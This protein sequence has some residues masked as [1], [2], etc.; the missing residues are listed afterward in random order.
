MTA[1]TPLVVL[2]DIYVTGLLAK[3]CNIAQTNSIHFL[4]MGIENYCKVDI[5]KDAVIHRVDIEKM[6]KR[7]IGEKVL[8][9]IQGLEDR[10]CLDFVSL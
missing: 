8:N 4:Y 2:E 3:K 6:H 1:K 10:L 9:E 5:K 7:I